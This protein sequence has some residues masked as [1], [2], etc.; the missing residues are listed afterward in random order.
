MRTRLDSQ[1]ILGTRQAGLKHSN[2]LLYLNKKHVLFFFFL[3]FFL[4]QLAFKRCMYPNC[5]P[6]D[7]P[8]REAS[9]RRR[10]AHPRPQQPGSEGPAAG[11]T[12]TARQEEQREAAGERRRA[13]RRFRG[14]ERRGTQPGPRCGRS[15][16]Q[17]LLRPHRE[18]PDVVVVAASAR[19]PFPLL[20]RPSAP[21]ATQASRAGPRR[22][23]TAPQGRAGPGRAA[24]RL[25][26]PPHRPEQP[27]GP[28]GASPS[29]GWRRSARGRR[30]ARRPQVCSSMDAILAL[31]RGWAAAAS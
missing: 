26:S 24:G 20:P 14:T 11:P 1:A 17:R 31:A 9:A 19:P 6:S 7:H 18:P 13:G 28:R 15:L 21:P 12:A 4:S 29:R 25:R 10:A 5:I 27:D 22:G 30:Q 8:G 23:R 2:V 16:P 3:S